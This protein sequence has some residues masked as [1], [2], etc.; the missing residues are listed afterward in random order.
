VTLPPAAGAASPAQAGTHA[1]LHQFAG[2]EPDWAGY[3]DQLTAVQVSQL[4][5]VQVSQLTAAPP[6]G[7]ADRVCWASAPPPTCG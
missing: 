1:V 7:P 3:G 6:G 2:Q 5:A 4:T